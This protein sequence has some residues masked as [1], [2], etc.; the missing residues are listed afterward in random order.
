MNTTFLVN[1]D[2]DAH[3]RLE[4]IAETYGRSIEDLIE[5]SASEEALK[6]FRNR[7]DDPAKRSA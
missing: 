1:I 5:T 7:K 6:F 4:K 3:A 2:G